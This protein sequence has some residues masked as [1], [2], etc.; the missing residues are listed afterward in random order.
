V[1]PY[2][3]TEHATERYVQR[4]K[5]ALTEDQ[6]QTE[7]RRLL[8]M[9]GEPSE[10]EPAWAKPY[11]V[12]EADAWVEIAPGIGCPI[13]IEKRCYRVLTVITIASCPPAAREARAAARRARKAQRKFEK[14]A[15]RQIREGRRPAEVHNPIFAKNRTPN[16]K[17][18]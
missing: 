6:A 9:A 14:R 2:A 13:S 3:I 12:Q 15:E 16:R 4:I 17:A 7:L 8:D 11:F 1:K 5:P 10:C 18:A